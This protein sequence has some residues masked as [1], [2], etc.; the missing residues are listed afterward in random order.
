M[1]ELARVFRSTDRGH[2]WTAA[3]TPLPAGKPT[4]GL[5][6][7]AFSDARRGFVAGGD[8]KEAKLAALNGARSG[9]GGATW[10]PAPIAPSGF[11][12]AVVAVPRTRSDLVAVG[13][14]GSAASHDGGRTWHPWGNM[15]LNAVAFVDSRTGWAVGPKGTIVRFVGSR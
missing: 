2:S 8:Y 15:P 13:P 4:A 10:F 3:S 6:T 12:S 14:A 5:F 11:F 9:D 7:V 1:R